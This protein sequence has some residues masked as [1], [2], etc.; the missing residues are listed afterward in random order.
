MIEIDFF[1]KR[2]REFR[3][4][5]GLSLD[6]GEAA[7]HS[8]H[9]ALLVEEF[10]EFL[11]AETLEDRADALADVVTIAC[12]YLLDAGDHCRADVL[13]I[14]EN[15]QR[16]ADAW[17]IDLP[18]AFLLVHESNMSKLVLGDAE[19]RATLAKYDAEGVGLDVRHVGEQ[20]GIPVMA[21]YAA[22]DGRYPRG[23]LLKG[24]TYH[25]PAWDRV[26]V[27]QR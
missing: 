12:G 24:A 14:V 1:L 16:T 6:A 3:A 18:G 13:R 22:Q 26:G 27:W 5:T 4:C 25:Q 11:A 19:L 15:C 8:L 9:L 2:V 21:V 10:D 7:D 17:G 23:K 20:L